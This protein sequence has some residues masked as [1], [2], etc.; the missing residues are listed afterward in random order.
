[1]TDLRTVADRLEARGLSRTPPL[2]LLTRWRALLAGEDP[3][4]EDAGHEAGDGVP[5]TRYTFVAVTNTAVCYLLAEHDDDWWAYDPHISTPNPG[6]ITPRS[7]TTWRRPLSAVSEIT[8]G[9][10]VWQWLPPAHG[11]VPSPTPSYIV[12]IAGDTIDLPLPARHRRA[13]PPDPQPAITQLTQVWDRG[14]R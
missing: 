14:H 4:F 1:M 9:G 2:V 13:S 3:L 11:G 6:H 12:T 5:G 10:D 7:L 8:L